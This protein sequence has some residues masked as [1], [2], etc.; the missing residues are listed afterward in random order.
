[1]DQKYSKHM[2]SQVDL[3]LIYRIF[4]NHPR[5]AS[6]EDPK[7]F[8]NKTLPN[9]ID[10]KK[11]DNFNDTVNIIFG[12]SHAEFLGR[13]FKEV[14]NEMIGDQ[15]IN[16]TFCF[17]TGATTLIGSVQ[18]ESYYNNVLRSLVIILEGLTKK[19]E[20]KFFS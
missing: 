5:R 18:S 17:W 10:L 12:D 9:L 8:E 14:T 3:D 20:F 6:L 13:F 15:G 7:Y 11:W 2:I 4:S 1:M 16:R 19:F